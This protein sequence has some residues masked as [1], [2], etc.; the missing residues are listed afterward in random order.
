M[1]FVL[2]EFGKQTQYRRGSL[3]VLA[4]LQDLDDSSE[5]QKPLLPGYMRDRSMS[6]FSPES[7]TRSAAQSVMASSWYNWLSL[8]VVLVSV[9]AVIWT[10]NS[11]S[12]GP[13]TKVWCPSISSLLGSVSS[14]HG[15]DNS[16]V[17]GNR[18]MGVS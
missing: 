5:A 15:F 16:A 8:G 2:Q 11:A 4:A 7:S 17:Q 6:L 10:P 1:C 12:T 13:D 9:I 18:F 3:V 14:L